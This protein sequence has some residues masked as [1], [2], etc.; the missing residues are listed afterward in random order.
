MRTTSERTDAIEKRTRAL[1]RRQKKRRSLLT[2]GLSA[3]ACLA[4][5]V[6]A[7]LAMPGL[8]KQQAFK[9]SASGAASVFHA[10]SAAGYVIIGVLA[11]ALGCCVT[12]LC[13]RLRRRN[14]ED[15]DGRDC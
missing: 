10:S 3:A 1:K 14:G 2:A 7:A 4:L 15:H 9:T 11:F 6:A 12:I 5:I 13:Y 8:M